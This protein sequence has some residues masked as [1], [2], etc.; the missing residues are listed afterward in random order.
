VTAVAVVASA[1]VGVGIGMA[2]DYEY[3]ISGWA[4]NRGLQAENAA[5]DDGFGEITSRV[6]GARATIDAITLPS[7][8][9]VFSFF[10]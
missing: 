4:A 9:G 6:I 7:V 10:F 5:L 3:D 8:F 1:A 2:L